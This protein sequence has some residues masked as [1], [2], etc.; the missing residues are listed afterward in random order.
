MKK[1]FISVLLGLCLAFS[2]ASGVMLVSGQEAAGAASAEA[3]QRYGINGVSVPFTVTGTVAEN[4]SL[5][6]AVSTQAD[7]YTACVSFGVRFT[8]T[9]SQF[10]AKTFSSDGAELSFGENYVDVSLA[11]GAEN[12]LQFKVRNQFNPDSL[13]GIWEIYLNGTL[14]E[15]DTAP[16]AET[17]L[18]F[19]DGCGYVNAAY[20]GAGDVSVQLG[21]VTS[22]QE[23]M[24]D[25]NNNFGA[26]KEHWS[27][28]FAAGLNTPVLAGYGKGGYFSLKPNYASGQYT[29]YK[30]DRTYALDGL[31]LIF[32]YYMPEGQSSDYRIMYSNGSVFQ[33]GFFIR[34]GSAADMAKITFYGNMTEVG[35]IEVPF[36]FNGT[37]SIK[38][39]T[40]PETGKWGVEINGGRYLEDCSDII[41]NDVETRFSNQQANIYL[42]DADA[43]TDNVISIRA[44][45]NG[46]FSGAPSGW[47]GADETTKFEIA[48]SGNV[49]VTSQDGAFKAVKT[50]TVCDV[51]KFT[52]DFGIRKE[53]SNTQGVSIVLSSSQDWY[54]NGHTGVLL[55]FRYAET[56]GAYTIY[57]AEVGVYS[58]GKYT[59][60]GTAQTSKFYLNAINHM[61]FGK[62]L[63]G[64]VLRLNEEE[65]AFDGDISAG[66]NG[67][68]SAY[69]SNKAY[70]QVHSK[71]EAGTAYEYKST[72]NI[73]AQLQYP[74][75]WAPGAAGGSDFG[76]PSYEGEQILIPPSGALGYSAIK[77]D[78]RVPVDGFSFEFELLRSGGDDGKIFS[79]IIAN[80]TSWYQKCKSVMFMFRPK[81]IEGGVYDKASFSLAYSDAD[82]GWDLE[83]DASKG[84]ASVEVDFNWQGK[85][86]IALRNEDDRWIITINGK[87]ISSEVS[88]TSKIESVIGGFSENQGVL[89]LWNGE[90][91]T[92]C[93]LGQ[94][95]E[96]EPPKTQ[97][98]VIGSFNFDDCTVGQ[99]IRIDL[100]Q[101]FSD[102][103][104]D[105]L[106]YSADKG[107][108]D[109]T[110]WV[111]TVS[112]EG[113]QFVTI[114]ATDQGQPEL[115]ADYLVRINTKPAENT[116]SGGGCSSAVSVSAAL[117]AAGICLAGA[118]LLC[119][120]TAK[121]S[122]KNEK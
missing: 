55:T 59:A 40:D 79:V 66:I 116:S 52:H 67:V 36:N 88:A 11:G 86:T 72:Y 13:A 16:I 31:E 26:A 112:R 115:Q 25:L 84:G 50:D 85:N 90:A 71:G 78:K 83:G 46:V 99:E 108:I 97:A 107:T 103:N 68:L 101:L 49:R 73:L 74:T 80:S 57:D 60:L 12:T 106:T 111:Y 75:N 54:E 23:E 20:T 114:T 47:E 100:T 119:I 44:I 122:K 76:E 64:W 18:S 63:G 33:F 22:V 8:A 102:K 38:V 3:D 28:N 14:L 24:K 17:Q 69:E 61:A 93:T 41:K 45:N 43:C 51:T 19:S 27:I 120:R 4:E 96:I 39:C 53:G 62:T 9:G 113:L 98:I 65:L 110:S 70:L 87:D 30:S 7:T 121:K 35:N 105:G 104:G 6:V 2:L 91:F 58:G 109:G 5:D 32:D 81:G 118:S 34:N 92:V 48:E 89:Q 29:A 77:I 94:L 95:T 21:E 37:N 10:R 42:W 117:G 56:I 1:L 15:L 82:Q